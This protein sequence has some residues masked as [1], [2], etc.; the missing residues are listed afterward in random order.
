VPLKAGTD[1]GLLK[2][3]FVVPRDAPTVVPVNPGTA[4][5]LLR[6]EFVPSVPPVAVPAKP[7]T[8][9]GLLKLAFRL[10]PSAGAAAFEPAFVL[11]PAPVEVAVEPA[12]VFVLG[13][14]P[15]EVVVVP[16]AAAVVPPVT[17]TVAPPEVVVIAGGV[18]VIAGI[19]VDVGAVAV[20]VVAAVGVVDA[21][22]V[23]AVGAAGM[24]TPEVFVGA[25][26]TV[27][28]MTP[29]MG[30]TFDGM[31]PVPSTAVEM[32][33]SAAVP[34]AVVTD[35]DSGATCASARIPASA[36][37]APT[38]STRGLRRLMRSMPSKTSNRC[39]S[40]AAAGHPRAG[41][42][43]KGVAQ[44][45]RIDERRGGARS[46]KLRGRGRLIRREIPPTRCH[47]E[48]KRDLYCALVL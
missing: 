8:V 3:L 1:E 23:G 37:A 21:V 18:V 41:G 24:T 17:A 7:D 28:P 14:A 22:D 27:G 33:V 5:G 38:A 46:D 4:D 25:A 43:E 12:F 6:L 26:I 30:A 45:R 39:S 2:L 32:I 20:G 15:V 48:T 9:D 36:S 35:P 42:D 19:V 40:R 44:P 13:P 10:L 31:L 47:P 29:T 34:A 11:E 16:L